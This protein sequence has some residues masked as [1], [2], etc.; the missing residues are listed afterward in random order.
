MNR[1]I[2]YDTYQM[3]TKTLQKGYVIFI[4]FYSQSIN[5]ERF[6]AGTVVCS[7]EK[8]EININALYAENSK[9]TSQ[10]GNISLGG[11]HGSVS[12]KTENG[13]IKIGKYFVFYN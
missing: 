11:C 4:Y 10:S 5:G 1:I 2:I 3:W 12:A 7:T 8:G 9:F 6:Q 13:N